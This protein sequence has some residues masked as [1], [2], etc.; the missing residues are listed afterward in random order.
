VTR[1]V[2]LL[3]FI[4]LI[5]F[6]SPFSVF[7][8][9]EDSTRLIFHQPKQEFSIIF[10]TKIPVGVFGSDYVYT[11][12]KDLSESI[13]N[14]VEG[15]TGGMG[16]NVGFDFNFS[17]YYYFNK[18]P[19]RTIG[20]IKVTY[21]SFSSVPFEWEKS[22]YVFDGAQFK[23]F[24][25]YSF[26]LGPVMRVAIIKKVALQFYS[27]LCLTYCRNAYW[28]N[29]TSYVE[30]DED[31]NRYSVSDNSEF[32]MNNSAGIRNETGIALRLAHFLVELNYSF[33]KMKFKNIHF[34]RNISV[35]VEAYNSWNHSYEYYDSASE[36][37]TTAL[38]A[39][40]PTGMIGFSV[41][42]IFGK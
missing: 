10:G 42:Y 34:E 4:A 9:S 18:K 24:Q 28:K 25:F 5:I 13:S 21:L 1:P 38:S 17:G 30:Y 29:N 32:K 19:V 22:G 2:S 8:S 15:E 27:Q 20:G 41:G 3:L 6:T 23:N 40:M 33:G 7:G 31:M 12:G 37:S 35:S 39:K 26:K 14:T 36:N 16:A 11:S